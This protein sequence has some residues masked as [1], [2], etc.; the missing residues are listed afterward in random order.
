L[1]PVFTTVGEEKVAVAVNATVKD[2]TELRIKEQDLV[3]A[4]QKAEEA[5]KAK[6]KFLAHMSHELRTPMVGILGM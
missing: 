2:M 1:Y 4:K 6:T 5:D 3:K